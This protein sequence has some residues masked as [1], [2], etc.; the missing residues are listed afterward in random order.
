MADGLNQIAD[1]P[2][3]IGVVDGM[4]KNEAVLTIGKQSVSLE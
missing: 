3:P 4:W 2:D 1:L